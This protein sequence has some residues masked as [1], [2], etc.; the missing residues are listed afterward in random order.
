MPEKNRVLNL[1]AY[2]NYT[3]ICMTIYRVL[4]NSVSVDFVDIVHF[5]QCHIMIMKN[6]GHIIKKH[7]QYCDIR[8]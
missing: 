3:C 2:E 5:S 1:V 8:L 4:L 6:Q 7:L